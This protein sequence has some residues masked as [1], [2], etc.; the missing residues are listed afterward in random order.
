[1]KPGCTM[2]ILSGVAPFA[3]PEFPLF[4]IVHGA[5]ADPAELAKLHGSSGQHHFLLAA[6]IAC[7]SFGCGPIWFE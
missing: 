6:E 1:M 5:L 4:Q 3:A 2:L 7:H